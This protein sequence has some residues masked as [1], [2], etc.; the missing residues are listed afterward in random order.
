M[1]AESVEEVLEAQV[2]A[3]NQYDKLLPILY[4]ANLRPLIIIV[5]SKPIEK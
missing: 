5:N 4:R 3:K 1:P 2:I